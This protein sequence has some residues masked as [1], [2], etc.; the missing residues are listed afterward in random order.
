MPGD[1]AGQ[2]GFGRGGAGSWVGFL[3]Q[4]HGGFHAFADHGQGGVDGEKADGGGG[5]IAI[6]EAGGRSPSLKANGENFKGS[7]GGERRDGARFHLV[8]AETGGGGGGIDDEGAGG[9]DGIRQAAGI[10]V[11]LFPR[12]AGAVVLE[13]GV[14]GGFVGGGQLGPGEV[15]GIASRISRPRRYFVC[16]PTVVAVISVPAGNCSI[17]PEPSLVSKRSMRT[18]T[19]LGCPAES[20][21]RTLWMAV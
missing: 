16:S 15:E 17:G 8:Q 2:G 9:S 6:L 21:A 13:D 4:F 5:D 3:N 19:S 20:S 10:G 1:L 11:P 12:A 18:R 7:G 14:L